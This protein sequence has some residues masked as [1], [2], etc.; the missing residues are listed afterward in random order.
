MNSNPSQQPFVISR[1]FDAPQELVW[2]TWT[3][4]EHMS[5][6]GP[7]GVTIS[8]ARMDFRPGG[9]FHYCMTTPDGHTMWGRWV[10]REVSAQGK[11]V[12]ISSFSDSEGGITRHPMSATW[13]LELLST[14]TFEAKNGKTLVTIQWLPINATEV[15]CKTFDA[16]HE[17]MKGG[18]GGTL[19]RL[20]EYLAAIQTTKH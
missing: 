2:K 7:R 14:I 12:F 8:H 11:L 19:D 17:S 20:A 10:I 4:E 1:L 6:W 16:G 18:W 15:E 13:P 3:D 9:I 5:W